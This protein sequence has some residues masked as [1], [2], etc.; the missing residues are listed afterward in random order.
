MKEK[1]SLGSLLFGG[2]LS[3]LISKARTDVC[4]SFLIHSSN[5]VLVSNQQDAAFDLL[6]LLSVSS[7]LIIFNI[8]YYSVVTYVLEVS[9]VTHFILLYRQQE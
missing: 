6:G 8:L 5:I 4:V 7:S 9:E 2:F 3:D 1:P